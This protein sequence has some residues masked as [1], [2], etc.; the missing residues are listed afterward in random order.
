MSKIVYAGA[1][2]ALIVLTAGLL[3]LTAQSVLGSGAPD[4]E[5]VLDEFRGQNLEVG[6]VQPLVESGESPGPLPPDLRRR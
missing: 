1:G 6:E 3:W 2:L 4:P 5:A